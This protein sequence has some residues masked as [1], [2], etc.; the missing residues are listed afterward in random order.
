MLLFLD[1][2]GVR[3]VSKE[4][5]CFF[6]ALKKYVCLYRLPMKPPVLAIIYV[7]TWRLTLSP[8]NVIPTEPETSSLM[9]LV[10]IPTGD[11]LEGPMIDMERC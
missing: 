6:I 9:S 10:D 8:M 1:G 7:A 5:L 3:S 11:P 4:R 2:A